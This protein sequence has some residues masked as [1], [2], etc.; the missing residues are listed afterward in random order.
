M[1]IKLVKKLVKSTQKNI[2]N[3]KSDVVGPSADVSLFCHI[4]L[5]KIKVNEYF[6]HIGY[7]GIFQVC[8][9]QDD[10]LKYW[11]LRSENLKIS[12]VPHIVLTTSTL[13]TV[14]EIFH[15]TKRL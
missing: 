11:Y 12:K 2:K 14:M 13:E 15:K 8:V 3:G 6:E 7:S 1:E 4:S 10:Q 9:F 5:K